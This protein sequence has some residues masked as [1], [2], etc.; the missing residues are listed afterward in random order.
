LLVGVQ[1]AAQQQLRAGI[2]EFD[3]HRAGVSA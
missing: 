3:V 1:R 2:D